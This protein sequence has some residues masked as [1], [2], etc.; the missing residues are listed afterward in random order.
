M[1]LV[2]K[3]SDGGGCGHVISAVVGGR[4]L[5]VLS[6]KFDLPSL[7]VG[8]LSRQMG[9]RFLFVPLSRTQWDGCTVER[10][11]SGTDAGA[12]YTTQKRGGHAH[13]TEPIKMYLGTHHD[14]DYIRQLISISWIA[15]LTCDTPIDVEDTIR[16]FRYDLTIRSYDTIL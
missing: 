13:Q 10:V 9:I 7:V 14:G 6:V 8:G 5:A 4:V 1:A 2:V 16:S 3:G 11:H 12:W 15:H